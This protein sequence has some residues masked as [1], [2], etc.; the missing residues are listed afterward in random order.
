MKSFFFKKKIMLS[1]PR[2]TIVMPN[3]LHG[4]YNVLFFFQCYH[5]FYKKKK[6]KEIVNDTS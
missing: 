6:E 4:T 3:T 1:F 2:Q 5:C